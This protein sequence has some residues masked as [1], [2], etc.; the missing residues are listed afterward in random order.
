MVTCCRI[1]GVE[2]VKF[3]K[4]TWVHKISTCVTKGTIFNWIDLITSSLKTSVR[5]EKTLVEG[6]NP[7]FYMASYLIDGACVQHEF[8]E[9]GWKWILSN[10]STTCAYI[11]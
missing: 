7:E 11:L 4:E 10:C 1:Y 5:R 9:I 8:L 2:D 3:F 6:E